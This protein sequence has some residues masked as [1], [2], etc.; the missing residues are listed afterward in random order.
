MPI[1]ILCA[2]DLW[3][4]KLNYE[5][6]FVSPPS[7]G[8]L[9]QKVESVFGPELAV[10]RPPDVPQSQSFAIDRIQ[11]FDERSQ[12]WVELLTPAQLQDFSQVYIFQKENDYHREVQSKIPPPV[13]APITRS[14]TSAS[15]VPSIPRTSY[16]AMNTFSSHHGPVPSSYKS[17]H[18]VPGIGTPFVG[19]PS[20]VVSQAQLAS[21]ESSSAFVG[22]TVPFPEKQRS[23]FDELT[24]KNARGFNVDSFTT[25]LHRLRIEYPSHTIGDMFRKADVNND[26]I[27]SYD[28]WRTLS[29]LYPTLLDSLYFRIKDYWTDNRQH[30]DMETAKR[31]LQE[32]REREREARIASMEQ[33]AVTAG[34]EQKVA[35]QTATAQ[36]AQQ[37]EKDAKTVLEAAHDDTER[38]RQEL[39]DRHID[40][41]QFKEHER[42]KQLAVLEA[43]REVEA[44][45]RRLAVQEVESVKGEEVL[46]EMERRVAEQRREL[47][48]LHSVTDKVRGELAAAH[49]AERLATMALQDAQRDTQ[50]ASERVLLAETEVTARQEREREVAMCHRE[51]Q[52][53]TSRQLAKRDIEE[54]ELQACKEKETAKTAVEQETSRF[55]EEQD[56]YVQRLERENSDLNVKRRQVEEEERSLLEQELRIREMRDSL[57]ENE[58]RLRN[59]QRTFHSAHGRGATAADTTNSPLRGSPARKS[60]LAF[61]LASGTPM[62]VMPS[63]SPSGLPTSLRFDSVLKFESAPA[64]S[65]IPAPARGISPARSMIA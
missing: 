43:Q 35:L 21:H 4:T 12:Q 62:G 8:D 55:V 5:V 38:G 56:D 46:K 28:E 59:E 58:T 3:G 45:Q 61:G 36:E 53:E 11:T 2:A 6:L 19:T 64:L 22:P 60:S 17:A 25:V 57:E 37:R 33:Q 7:L 47:D 1:T 48:R 16:P 49:S 20:H 34:Q 26:A 24:S 52:S 31:R 51:S 30:Q 50:T 14:Y 42:S 13:P 15:P 9:Q 29:E 23:V 41:N 39:R 27:I 18:M 10:R 63:V 44:V 65:A 32:L 40:Q 54:R